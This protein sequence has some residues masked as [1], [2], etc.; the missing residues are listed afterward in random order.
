MFEAPD[1]SELTSLLAG[2]D[3]TNLIAVGG[4]GAVYRAKQISLQRDVAIKVLPREMT[5]VEE[6][7]QSFRAE[8]KAMGRLHHPNLIAVHDFGEVDG[9]LYLIMDYVDGKS[10]HHSAH[11][12]VIDQ[13]EA[14]R[15][16]HG[17]CDG[18][19][20]AHEEGIIHRDIK[21]ANILLD[22][23]KQPRIGDFGLA[24]SADG[25]GGE[26]LHYGTP[27][28]TAPEIM[29]NSSQADER[30]DVYA[31]GVVLY[32]LLTG[33]LPGEGFVP[34]SQH[35]TVDKRFDK[36]VR[37]A[38]HPSP[39]M[40]FA[41]AGEMAKELKTLKEALSKPG[42]KLL[43]KAGGEDGGPAN[44]DTT[45]GVTG[46]TSA[47]AEALA[48]A[49]AEVHKR[50][51]IRNLVIIA[52]LL[53]VIA[54]VW[55]KYKRREA[56]IANQN[57]KE[58]KED[59]A[60]K[61]GGT[62]SNPGKQPG[63]PGPNRPTTPD[64]PGPGTTPA[65][66]PRR[67]VTLAEL[68]DSLAGGSR[69]RFPDAAWK[70]GDRKVYLVKNRMNWH[71][72]GRF[73]EEHG[74]FLATIADEDA[75]TA[76]AAKLPK[77]APVWV[78]GGLTGPSTWGWVDGTPWNL[79]PTPAGSGGRF[80]SMKSDGTIKALSGETRYH[81]VIT[82]DPSD[83]NPGTTAAQLKRLNDSLDQP[84]P[85]Y[86]PGTISDKK[87]RYL[88][89]QE[90]LGWD[91]AADRARKAGGYL[92]VPSDKE[93]NAFLKKALAKNLPT[94]TAAW[95]GGNFKAGAWTWATG[96]SWAFNDWTLKPLHAMDPDHTAVRLVIGANGGW[97]HVD[98][99]GGDGPAAFIVEWSED[100]LETAEPAP[101]V[102]PLDLDSLKEKS[103][104]AVAR[105]TKK[106]AELILANGTAMNGDLDS[107]ISNGLHARARA[108]FR[109]VVTAARQ[110]VQP[111]G[112]INVEGEFPPLPADIGEAC[113]R[114]IAN[115]R[116][117][118]AQIEKSVETDRTAYL[119]KINDALEA[120]ES[121]R[122]LNQ[123]EDL[124]DEIEAIG[125]TTQTFFKHLGIQW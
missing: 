50:H 117:L 116:K 25:G 11:G 34:P 108:R 73:A 121:G 22:S 13:E 76:I 71:E 67:E 87:R 35:Q 17:I 28:Y 122:L 112:R 1:P 96:E 48:A 74:A 66:P 93:E 9:F 68:Q 91:E 118:D 69:S 62:P 99:D 61:P 14:V 115:Q 63:V 79:S 39:N 110:K 33:E 51:F 47:K 106:H 125:E 19:A 102:A 82:W 15:L 123:F 70:V 23:N 7:E 105:K 60:K 53:V 45:G 85:I 119:K 38:I 114:R 88:I 29:K 5:Q 124:S 52:V 42:S 109:G 20:H 46:E 49:E 32:E 31:I 95:I 4:M 2:Y 113:N 107:W 92:A 75:K 16:V 84:N 83:G 103:A 86:P 57:E 21:P 56:V 54:I 8:A 97:D 120:A 77:D 24:L 101:A 41:N 94:G 30:T 104:A 40:R 58:K 37:R 43:T 44:L 78:G 72:A 6:F 26:G 64:R 3:V 89:M 10:L 111:N 12:K 18:V 80:L 59:P 36:I 81:F 90:D 65:P 55:D 100:H 27:E 98:P